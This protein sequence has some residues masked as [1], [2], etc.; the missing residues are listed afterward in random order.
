MALLNNTNQIVEWGINSADLN[1][2]TIAAESI[3]KITD[4][5]ELQIVE[6]PG[7]TT[8]ISMPSFGDSM[9][10]VGNKIGKE[11]DKHIIAPVE[12]TLEEIAMNI[13][14][15]NIGSIGRGLVGVWSVLTSPV[16]IVAELTTV[17]AMS[18]E[19]DKPNIGPEVSS[20]LSVADQNF[21]NIF[22]LNLDGTP[23]SIQISLG[24]EPFQ[25]KNVIKMELRL[26]NAKA[27][28]YE[29][30]PVISKAPIANA[31]YAWMT[32]D[33]WKPQYWANFAVNVIPKNGTEY[34]LT[35]TVTI[36][37]KDDNNPWTVSPWLDQLPNEFT[38]DEFIKYNPNATNLKKSYIIN[39]GDEINL[40]VEVLTVWK[41]FDK[42]VFPLNPMKEAGT[43]V[44]WK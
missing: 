30:T 7:F 33:P 13:K 8:P 44:V 18:C 43:S 3:E 25:M 17:T 12:L 39:E 16:A 20:E 36:I 40:L 42:V 19:T 34:S 4:T 1:H 27:R 29:I 23:V 15:L 37:D 41:K 35:N 22:K 32:Q 24:N 28:Q 2:E 5:T 21:A 11:I 6:I 31:I 14:T 38:L 26:V 10:A 9:S